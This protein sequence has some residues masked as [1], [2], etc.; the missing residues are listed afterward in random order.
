[1]A[2]PARP[3]IIANF[4]NA[5]KRA[6]DVGIDHM[7]RLIEVLIEEPMSEAVAGISEHCLNRSALGCSVER[8]DT[9][10]CGK[11]GRDAVNPSTESTGYVSNQ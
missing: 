8:I 7:P 6:G 9:F 1:M 11:V 10:D 5:I 2:L 4:V 3:H